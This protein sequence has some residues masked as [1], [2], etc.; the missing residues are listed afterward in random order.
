MM[1]KTCCGLIEFMRSKHNVLMSLSRGNMVVT[2][3]DLWNIREQ[4]LFS[5]ALIFN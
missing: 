2:C 3:F 1:E 4:T 5:R